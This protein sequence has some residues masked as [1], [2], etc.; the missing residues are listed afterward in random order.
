MGP[1]R[2]NPHACIHLYHIT[3][4]EAIAHAKFKDGS[5]S[6]NYDTL[7]SAVARSHR[8]ILSRFNCLQKLLQ[9]VVFK[10]NRRER[11]RAAEFDLQIGTPWRRIMRKRRKRWEGSE[12]KK[13]QLDL[14]RTR[15][16]SCSRFTSARAAGVALETFCVR[17]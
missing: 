3:R 17:C 9:K 14:T 16:G 8:F 13:G 5:K 7:R 2:D 6:Q 10:I 15:F 4:R 1:A 12:E 11:V